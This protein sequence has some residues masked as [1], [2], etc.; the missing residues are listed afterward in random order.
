[1]G[2]GRRSLALWC[3]QNDVSQQVKCF[4]MKKLKFTVYFMFIVN[5]QVPGI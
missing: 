5:L 4:V 2:T 3:R 1:M